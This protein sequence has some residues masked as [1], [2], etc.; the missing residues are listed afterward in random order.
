MPKIL[1]LLYLNTF[2]EILNLLGIWN[3]PTYNNAL[4][5][6]VGRNLNAIIK[7]NIVLL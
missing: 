5:I 6:V 3:I 7:L 4:I 1:I 2:I